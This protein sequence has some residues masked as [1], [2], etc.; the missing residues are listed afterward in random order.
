[1]LPIVSLV[2]KEL[3]LK[4]TTAKPDPAATSV[5]ILWPCTEKPKNSYEDEL[6]K[7]LLALLL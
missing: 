1:M 2:E 5:Y 3:K 4:I 7:N 6:C